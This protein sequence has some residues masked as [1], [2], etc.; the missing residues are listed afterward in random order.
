MGLAQTTTMLF[1]FQPFTHRVF[2]LESNWQKY[3]AG[4]A[5]IYEGREAGQEYYREHNSEE[6]AHK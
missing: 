1:L 4:K 6:H 5:V 3:L 2:Y